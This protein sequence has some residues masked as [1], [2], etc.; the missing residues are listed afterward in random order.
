[1]LDGHHASAFVRVGA[2]VETTKALTGKFMEQVI[3][4]QT[5]YLPLYQ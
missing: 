3:G 4:G 1:M 5:Y 2:V